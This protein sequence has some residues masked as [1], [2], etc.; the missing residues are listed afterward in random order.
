MSQRRDF[1]TDSKGTP[2]FTGRG[3]NVINPVWLEE[4]VGTRRRFPD[5]LSLLGHLKGEQRKGAKSFAGGPI[6]IEIKL[7]EM[8]FADSEFRYICFNP[9]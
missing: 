3:S 8:M 4:N 5:V 7:V 2:I 6:E 9:N 1:E